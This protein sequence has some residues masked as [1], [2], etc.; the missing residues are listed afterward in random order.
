VRRDTSGGGGRD[1]FGG[2]FGGERDEGLQ[3]AR[4]TISGVLRRHKCVV[5]ARPLPARE[6]EICGPKQES[7]DGSLQPVRWRRPTAACS[8]GARTTR[9]HPTTWRWV[10]CLSPGETDWNS[11]YYHRW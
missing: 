2:L 1:F 6:H 4:R 8:S 5:A 11:V 9:W 10:S 7:A 3:A